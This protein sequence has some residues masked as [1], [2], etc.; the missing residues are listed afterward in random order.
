MVIG[1][2]NLKGG[3][4]KTTLTQNL[5]VA[6]AH[7]GKRVCIIDA[8]KNQN[9]LEWSGARRSNLPEVV[10]MGCTEPRAL[11]KLVDTQK[12]IYEIVLIDGTPDLGEMTTRIMLAS[13]LLLVPLLPSGH[14]F[15]SMVLLLQ[16][17]EQA[18]GFKPELPAYFILNKFDE[19]VNFHADMV[20]LLGNYDIPILTARVKSR[21]A[22]AQTGVSGMGVLEWTDQKAIEEIEALANEVLAKAVLIQLN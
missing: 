16:R 5:A 6:Y 4:G 20:E 13:D 3:V 18:K 7:Q 9:S 17:F 22:Y 2:T 10:V 12:E 11:N 1:I 19:R 15:R 8:D 14:D 21:I